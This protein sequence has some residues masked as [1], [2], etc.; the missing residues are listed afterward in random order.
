[1]KKINLLLVAILLVVTVSAQNR[2]AEKKLVGTWTLENIYLENADEFAQTILGLYVGIF[3]QQISDLEDMIK[4]AENED[5]KNDYITKLEEVKKQKED[6]SLET[7][8]SEFKQELDNL[9]GSLQFLFNKD[10][11]YKNIS[12]DID[13]TWKI[14]KKATE[15]IVKEGEREVVFHISKLTKDKLFV[16]ILEE[17]GEIK[18]TLNMEFKKDKK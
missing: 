3:D 2:R 10:K 14:N 6:Y 11:T 16:T 1:M 5:D 7:I 4:E 15:L 18:M 9:I 17:Q 13:G 8:K 12:D